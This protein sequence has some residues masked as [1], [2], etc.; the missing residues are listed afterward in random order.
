[1]KHSKVFR[2]QVQYTTRTWVN[3]QQT[4]QHDSKYTGQFFFSQ[5]IWWVVPYFFK[6]HEVFFDSRVIGYQR[7]SQEKPKLLKQ[8]DKWPQSCRLHPFL[9]EK[10]IPIGGEKDA[11]MILAIKA[12]FCKQAKNSPWLYSPCLTRIQPYPH[13]LV[14]VRA[15]WLVIEFQ[16]STR[17]WQGIVLITILEEQLAER[18]NSNEK[19]VRI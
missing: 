7:G 1:M 11:H 10:P 14:K 17:C 4:I 13:F 18:D 3:I 16:A 8:N 15:C 9:I 5:N 19:R 6:P 12:K 2:L